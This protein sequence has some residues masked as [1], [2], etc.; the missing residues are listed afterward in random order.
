VSG[1]VA[2]TPLVSVG[3]PVFNGEGTIRVALESV[4][5]QTHENLEVLVYNNGSTDGTEA[6]VLDFQRNDSRVKYRAGKANLGW[7]HSFSETFRMS[8]GP[9]FVWLGA[10][11]QLGSSA[12]EEGVGLLESDQEVGV[13]VPLITAYLE[14]HE[15]PVYEVH[16]QGFGSDVSE[17]TKLVRSI[18]QLPVSCI[19]GLFRSE[20]LRASRLL[21]PIYMADV[22][23]L[24]EV[25]LRTAIVFNANQH[26]RYNMRTEWRTPAEELSITFG[27][28]LP[29]WSS[30]P[31]LMLLLEKV[32][33]LKGVTPTRFRWITYSALI[34]GAEL[35]RLTWRALWRL[36]R[37]L[38]G[39]TALRAF[40]TAFYW[41]H[42]LPGY[43]RVLDPTAYEERIVLPTLGL[44]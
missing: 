20:V 24:Q 8:S 30:V 41:Q 18:R 38:F 2:S 11:D 25:A 43:M 44:E 3:I 1:Q 37:K 28:E 35:W 36:A 15:D 21:P 32:R 16:F 6:V 29:R 33:R 39:R 17:F 31:A 7:T 40:G 13:S 26:L 5:A 9:Y 10:D 4:L 42:M 19:Y 22:V 14:D 23:L 12:L 27:E 34:A